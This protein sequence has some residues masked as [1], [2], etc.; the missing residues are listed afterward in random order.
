MRRPVGLLAA[1]LLVCPIWLAPSPAQAAGETPASGQGPTVPSGH[2]EGAFARFGSIQTVAIDL[3][4]AGETPGGTFDIPDLG[5]QGE[6]LA[7]VAYEAPVLKFKL[8]YG[9]FAMRLHP[10]VGEMTGENRDWDP[11][12]S[13]HLKRLPAPPPAVAREEIRFRNGA[14]S[15]AGTL[16]KPLGAPPYPAVVLVHGSGP[17]GR[18]RWAYRSVGDLFARHGVAA[19]VYDKRGVGESKGDMTTATFDDLAGDVVAAVEALSRRGDIDRRRIGLF[20][21]SQGGW[22]APLAATK[23]PG[24]AFLILNKGSAASVAEQERQRV[25][26]T[27]RADGF[28]EPEIAE[29]VAYTRLVFRAVDGAA[30]W[31]EVAKATEAARARK[32]SETVQLAESE[33][34]LEDW[35]RERFDPAPV[36]KRTTIPVLALFGGK[37]T[38]VPP[39]ENVD[40]LRDLLRQAGNRDVTVR[41]LPGEGHSV[42][43]GQS[44][45]G[46]DWSWPDGYWV[47]DRRDPEFEEAV[48][49]WLPERLRRGRTRGGAPGDATRSMR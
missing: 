17:Q 42:F 11:P 38:L 43:L 10:D 28:S 36:L 23:T 30:G 6:P 26:H 27:L 40:R 31:P 14:V 49:A 2:W 8:L 5:L 24:I 34:D 47:W 19:L 44:L 1:L 32:W 12:V 33:K 46:G 13:L 39:A 3:A 20:G 25:E 37:D 18:E 15:L 21:S 29:A 16:I 7:E 22:L 48:F 41:I 45:R 4:P 35:R 9:R